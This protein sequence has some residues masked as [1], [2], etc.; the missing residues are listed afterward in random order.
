MVD[1]VLSKLLAADS[2]LE[3]QEARLVAQLEALQAKRGS[4]KSVMQIFE[5][6][7]PTAMVNTAEVAPTQ[8]SDVAGDQPKEKPAKEASRRK[9]KATTDKPTQPPKTSSRSKSLR[10]GWQKYMRDEHIETPLPAVVAGILKSKPK[11][12]FEIQ[13]VVDAIVGADIPAKD[14][15][16]ARNRIS[17]I[18]AEGARKKEWHRPKPGYYRLSR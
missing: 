15:K 10:R 17:N 18:L 8:I 3:A 11:K 4:L 7:T 9:A 5:P 1:S 2:D 12:A 6:D 16:G 14:R 13:E